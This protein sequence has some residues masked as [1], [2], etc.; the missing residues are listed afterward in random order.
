[1]RTACR[2]R[3]AVTAQP[4]DFSWGHPTQH[5]LFR[6]GAAC[7]GRHHPA[8]PTGQSPGQ[9]KKA[10]YQGKEDNTMAN[11]SYAGKIKNTGTQSVNALYPSGGTNKGNRAISGEDLRNKSKKSGK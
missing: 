8:E 5:L 9:G 7:D 2:L 1:M 10:E 6:G 11:K 4:P 3:R